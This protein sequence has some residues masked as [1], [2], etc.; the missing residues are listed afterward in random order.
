MT[1]GQVTG[2]RQVQGQA[3]TSGLV[4]QTRRVGGQAWSWAWAQAW[5]RAWARAWAQAWAQA[6]L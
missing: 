5:A 1:A 3:E 2:L 4:A 6:Q